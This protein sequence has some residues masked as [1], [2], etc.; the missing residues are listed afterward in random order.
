[1]SK[2]R[3]VQLQPAQ[4]LILALLLLMTGAL[5]LILRDSVR[6]FVVIPL[7]YLAC[8]AGVIL[9]TIPQSL[10]LAVL[11]AVCVY[12]IARSVA[13]R[14]ESPLWPSSAPETSASRGPLGFWAAYL[15]SVEDSPHAR[16]SLA[17][18]LRA[19]ILKM[20]AQQHGIEPDEVLQLLRAN[21]RDGDAD[22][23][24]DANA[25]LSVPPDVRKI[26]L[27]WQ[28]WTRAAPAGPS[29]R[30]LQ[31]LRARLWPRTQRDSDSDRVDKGLRAA[32]KFIEAQSGNPTDNQS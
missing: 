7:A 18:A 21:K 10:L 6:E 19:L 25:A 27:D 28:S 31:R 2:L 26:L 32:V 1:M 23:D 3:R 12:I 29:S 5:V 22:G 20:L 8:L 14:D 17:R 13:W 9:R 24:G 11:L 15:N 4:V 16:E 30:R